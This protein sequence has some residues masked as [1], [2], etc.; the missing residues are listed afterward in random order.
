MA[1]WIRGRRTLGGLLALTVAG[2]IAA[3]D[4]GLAEAQTTLAPPV[5]AL[6]G[7]YVKPETGWSEADVKAA[8]TGLESQVGRKLAIDHHY[9]AWSVSFPRWKEPWDLE[10]GRIPMVSWGGTD[11]AEINAGSH[12]AMIRT[13][14]RD[15][16]TLPGRVLMRWFY[17]MD[18]DFLSASAVSPADY[19]AAWQRIRGIFAEEG[20]TNVEW[21]WCPTTWGFTEGLAPAYYPGDGYVDWICADGYNWAP[22]KPGASWREFEEIFRDF[23][24]WGV[25]RGKPLMIGETGVQERDPGEKPAWFTN[26]AVAI[27]DRMPAIK[28]F[29][30]FNSA[31]ISNQGIANDWRVTTSEGSLDAFRMMAQDPYF[32]GTGALVVPGSEAGGLEPVTL[33]VRQKRRDRRKIRVT[34]EGPAQATTS[35]RVWQV[36]AR[37]K[38]TGFD[39]WTT[40][41][42]TSATYRGRPGHRY[43]FSARAEVAGAASAWGPDACIAVPLNDRALKGG[44]WDRMR[45][46]RSYLRTVSTTR[47]AGAVL[48]TGPVLAHRVA[49]VVTTSPEGGPVMVMLGRRKLGKVSLRS[50]QRRANRLLRL[51]ALTEPTRG[52]IRV[53]SLT[54]GA[55][56]SIEGVVLNG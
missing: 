17:E 53:R 46:R 11:T 1:T 13:R 47:R 35:L 10:H 43:C 24:D 5:G 22:T 49:L 4:H 51:D 38:A 8:V 39:H 50:G 28:A 41:P 25:Q 27:R 26:A 30:Y 52:R 33:D 7:A 19:T 34:W 18:S 9:Y 29:V 21:V 32:G 48:R 36:A 14:A 45:S 40:K 12:D 16:A 37:G 15:V 42:G 44:G 3:T 55:E 23:Y 20:A 31:R 56:V 2:G 54:R 6:L